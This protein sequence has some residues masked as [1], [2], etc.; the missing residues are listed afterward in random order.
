MKYIYIVTCHYAS[1][2]GLDRGSSEHFFLKKDEAI[3][4]SA[5]STG[6]GMWAS[7][8]EKPIGSYPKPKKRIK[9]GKAF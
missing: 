8:R 9:K 6:P 7:W 2:H 3:R 5:N 1:D 4:F